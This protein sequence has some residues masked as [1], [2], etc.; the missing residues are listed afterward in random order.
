MPA[1]TPKLPSIWN[2]GSGHRRDLDR[3]CHQDT[4]LP[5]HQMATGEAYY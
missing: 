4:P 2:G 5:A 3:F 1:V